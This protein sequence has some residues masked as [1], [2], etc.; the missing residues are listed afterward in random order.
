MRVHWLKW[1]PGQFLF[2]HHFAVHVPEPPVPLPAAFASAYTYYSAA[3]QSG[4]MMQQ[5][6]HGA[7]VSTSQLSFSLVIFL[8]PAV[9]CVLSPCSRF[10]PASIRVR[11]SREIARNRLLL[12]C[13]WT[14]FPYGHLWPI[15][16]LNWSRGSSGVWKEF[17]NNDNKKIV[18]KCKHTC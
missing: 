12:H 11:T 3:Q 4:S 6:P 13:C 2:V 10:L 9:C 1:N 17:H 14:A 16:K 15:R 7:K 8:L 18:H 5:D